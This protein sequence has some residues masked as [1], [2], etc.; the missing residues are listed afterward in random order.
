L[1]FF[2][3]GIPANITLKNGEKY[4]GVLSGT[5]LDPTEMRYVFKMVKKISAGDAQVNGSSDLS[6]EYVG[7]GENHVKSFDIGDV[8]DFNCNGVVLNQGQ[9]RAQNGM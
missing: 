9:A 3:Q 4:T 1:F 6:D 7:H 5:S 8:A 2:P